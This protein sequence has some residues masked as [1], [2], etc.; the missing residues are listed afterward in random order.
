MSKTR[1][2]WLLLPVS[3]VVALYV[4]TPKSRNFEPIAPAAGMPRSAIERSSRFAAELPLAF[5]VNQGQAESAVDFVSRGPGY[6]LSLAATKARFSTTVRDRHNEPKAKP[7]SRLQMERTGVAPA[8]HSLQMRLVGANPGAAKKGIHP[9]PGKVNYFLGNDP[10]KWRTNVSTYAEVEYDNVYPGIDL[11]YHGSDR[12]LEYDFVVTPGSTPQTIGLKFDGASKLE[13]DAYGNLL[14]HTASGEIVQLRK[15]FIYQER[16]GNR[17]EV[18]GGFVL[19]KQ[20]VQ[21]RLNTYDTSRSVVI[22]PI[23]AF[24]THL[25]GSRSSSGQGIAVDSE[26]NV[27]VTGDTNSD[28]FPLTKPQQPKHGGS[29]DVFITKL[30]RDGS[31]ILYSTYIGGSG[32][33]VGYGIAVDAAGNAYITGDT[34]STNFPVENPLQK[35]MGGIFDAF[36]VKLSPDGSKLLYSTYIGGSQGDRGDAIALDG[37]GNAYITGYTYSTDF[38]VVTPIQTAFSDANVHCFVSKVNPS[39]SALVY[40][41]YLG[42]G[43]DRPDQATGIAVDS[44]GNAYITGYTNSVKF[45]SVNALQKFVGPTDV[46]VTK[47]NAAGSAFAY[48]TH[49]GGNADD[50]GM[51]ITVDA[52]GSAYVTGETESLDF[53][54]TLGAYGTK[55]VGVPT[56]GRMRQIC[57]GGDVFVSKLTPDGSKLIYSTFVSGTG[58]EVGRGIV[59]DAAGNAY[60]VGLTTSADFPAVNPL[61][62]NFGGDAFD[63]FIFKLN[64]TG[65]ALIYSSLLG[66]DKNDGGYA[67]ALDTKGNAYVTGYTYSTNFPTKNPLRNGEKGANPGYRD[68]FVTKISDAG[69]VK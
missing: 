56:P 11:R 60:V 36:A 21:F 22:D 38:P 69:G 58:F 63:A 41:T 47:I 43:D 7:L 48:S 15:P 52:A 53:P 45:P 5:E 61:Q 6:T 24:S 20:E 46:F 34:S 13:L 51:A 49:L 40:S 33:D 25:G 44:G 42:G 64:P 59:V 55:C 28:N 12:R 67:I 3:L 29:T 26:G 27:Y 4:A 57:A 17:K 10:T 16:D 66:G 37:S 30:S 31:K 50:E 2:F 14:V 9:L 23:F 65:T 39:G 54:V 62:K 19:A 1:L 35:S 8:Y 18:G 68:V 32:D